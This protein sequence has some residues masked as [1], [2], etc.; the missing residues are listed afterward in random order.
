MLKKDPN[1]DAL[2][3]GPKFDFSDGLH[4][5]LSLAVHGMALRI[6]IGLIYLLLAQVGTLGEALATE[7]VAQ[8]ERYIVSNRLSEADREK[9]LSE[10]RG[11]LWGKLTHGQPAELRAIFYTLEGDPTSYDFHTENPD[12]KQWCIRADITLEHPSQRHKKRDVFVH[13][14][15]EVFRLDIVTGAR[16]PDT[17]AREPKTYRLQLRDVVNPMTSRSKIRYTSARF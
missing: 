14:Y 3:S 2:I 13:H 6:S 10:I 15:C 12:G 8:A 11:F 7:S 5:T 17:E 4:R 9:V 1:I 16:I